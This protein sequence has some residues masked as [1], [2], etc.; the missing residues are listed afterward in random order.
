MSNKNVFYLN[1]EY[2]TLREWCLEIIHFL[3]TEFQ[4]EGMFYF[5]NQI[6]SL[7]ENI[8]KKRVLAK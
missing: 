1:A 8:D 2:E 5:T 4:E 3:Q 7:I 6:T